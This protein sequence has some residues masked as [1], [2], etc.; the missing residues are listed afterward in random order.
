MRGQL[1]S[2]RD[3]SGG[4][5]VESAPY[6]LADN[7]ARDLRNVVPT[8]RGAVRKRDGA[9]TLAT[10]GAA[11]TSLFA[12]L[13]PTLLIAAGGTVL[14]SI[15]AGG[16]LATIKTGMTAGARWS[17]VQAP[18]S[19]GQGPLFGVNGTD[20]QQWD[21][22][23]GSTSAWTAATGTFPS[24][25][26]WLLYHGSRV[27]AAG[28]SAYAGVPDPGSTLVFSN[29]GDPRDWPVANVVQFDP[30]DGEA[31]SGIGRL[32]QF[33]VVF[34]P[35]KMWVVFDLDTGANRPI[36]ENVGCVAHRSIVETPVGTFFLGKDAVYR[37]SQSS[38][39]PV[40]A[41]R[42]T[43]LIVAIPAG[44]RDL[45]AGGW[46][47]GHYYLSIPSASSATV[48]DLTLDFDSVHESWWLHSLAE[49]EWATWE[50]GAASVLY[51]ARP[52]ASKIV[53]RAFVAGVLQDGA[54]N[55]TAFW[56]SPFFTFKDLVRR[57]R[58]RM[59]HFDGK[60]HVQVS[61]ATDFSQQAAQLADVDFSGG[62]DGLFGTNDGTVFGNDDG[63][64]FGQVLDVDDARILNPGVAR[65]WSVIVGN[66]TAD[67]FEIESV[68]FALTGRKN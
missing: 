3:F 39:V 46:W 17:W 8:V 30:G 26:R 52:D 14:Y 44:K 57:K 27:W 6:S 29:L 36:G 21:G 63:S 55:F 9:Q 13:S 41:G 37:A 7:E 68:N 42:L 64:V 35:S 11:L 67:D 5:N 53:D 66:S 48:N 25:A 22:A 28:M 50:Q 23:A 62:V 12:A 56:K 20:A 40:T 34:K 61:V 58:V 49:A 24:G 19:G 45:A 59:V 60:G 43:P 47:N 2:Y 16:V 32:G 33:L 65:A 38:V 54:A 10:A 31:I 4:V 18:V 15:T 1:V 51:G